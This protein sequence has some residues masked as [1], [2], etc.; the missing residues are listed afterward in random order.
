MK[1]IRYLMTMAVALLMGSTATFGQDDFDPSFP[2]EPGAPGTDL[3]YSRIV[4][5]RN[6]EEGG[7]VSGAGK[8]VVDKYVTVYA[9]VNTGYRFVNWTDT[10]RLEYAASGYDAGES[11]P[12]RRQHQPR[13]AVHTEQLG[14]L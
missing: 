13:W 5:L 9:Y 7:T 1:I 2:V 6:I 8:Y 11:P 4:L 14:A 3:Y 12:C 10:L